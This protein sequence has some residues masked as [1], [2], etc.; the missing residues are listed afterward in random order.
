MHAVLITAYKDFPSL[1]RLVERLDRDFFRIYVHIDSIGSIDREQGEELKRLGAS[2]T[3]DHAIRWGSMAHLHAIIDLLR[4]AVG[5]GGIDYIHTISGQCYPVAGTARFK[6]RCDGRIFMNFEPVSEAS[7]DIRERYELRNL[8]YHLQTGSRAANR[9]Y[10]HVDGGGRWL[11]KSLGMKRTRLGPYAD[12]YKGIVWM[13]FPAAAAARLF[14]DPAADALLRA[15]R[16]SYIPEEVFFQTYFLNSDLRSLVVNDD[17]RY[18]DWRRRNGSVPAYLDETDAE[19]VLGSGALFARKVSSD[20]SAQ[21]LDLI[22]A[23]RFGEAP[24]RTPRRSKGRP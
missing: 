8:F 10:R 5:A 19:A 6:A 22:D 7:A 17:L 3:R 18:T 12:L 23:E 9:L 11:Q 13:S 15:I 1:A 4:A 16:T 24:I 14:E 21:L 2:V 20:I